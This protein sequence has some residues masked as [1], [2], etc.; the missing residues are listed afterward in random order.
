MNPSREEEDR[1][2]GRL[3]GEKEEGSLSRTRA[4]LAIEGGE[5]EEDP[6]G[7]R[8][9]VSVERPFPLSL[10]RDRVNISSRERG[11]ELGE[12]EGKETEIELASFGSPGSSSYQRNRNALEKNFLQRRRKWVV[13]YL[14]NANGSSK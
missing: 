3:E 2:G 12:K 14:F 8:G 1:E 4:F 6:E 7:R 11:S 5:E 10:G 9:E 13:W